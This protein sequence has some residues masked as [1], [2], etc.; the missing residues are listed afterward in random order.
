MET[1]SGTAV[2]DT[3]AVVYPWC[4]FLRGRLEIEERE[5]DGSLLKSPWWLLVAMP[6]TRR[7]A[8]AN[9][10]PR[11]REALELLSL[12]ALCDNAAWKWLLRDKCGVYFDTHERIRHEDLLMPRFIFVLD[13]HTKET[14]MWPTTLSSKFFFKLPATHVCNDDYVRA[15]Q[16]VLSIMRRIAPHIAAG[17]ASTIHEYPATHNAAKRESAMEI[18]FCLYFAPRVMDPVAFSTYLHSVLRIVQG[19]ASSDQY[20]GDYADFAAPFTLDAIQLNLT[21]FEI[22]EPVARVLTELFRLGVKISC[23]QLPLKATDFISDEECP[24]QALGTCLNAAVGVRETYF[25][26]LESDDD[27]SLLP[28]QSS[29]HWKN[30]VEA[31][32][33][34][35][36]SVDDRRFAALCA[37]LVES[38]CVKELTLESVFLNDSARARNL[39]WKWL[40]YALFSRET[41]TSVRKLVI[42]AASLRADDVDAIASVVGARFPAKQLLDPLWSIDDQLQDAHKDDAIHSV[43]LRRETVICLEPACCEAEWLSASVVLHEDAVFAVIN[44]NPASEWIEILVPGYGKCWVHRHFTV[45]SFY[46]REEETLSLRPRNPCAGKITS[47]TLALDRIEDSQGQVVASLIHLIGANLTSLVIQTNRLHGDC[48]DSILQSCPKL[49]TLSLKGAQIDTMDVFATA[50]EKYQCQLASITLNDFRIDVESLTRFAY[51]LADRKHPAAI[52]LRELCFGSFDRHHPLDESSMLAFVAMLERNKTLEYL[53]L[54]V[55]SSLFDVYAP[56]MLHHHHKLLTSPTGKLRFPMAQR[57]AFLSVISEHEAA[58]ISSHDDDH[59]HDNNNDEDTESSSCSSSSSSSSS[60]Q[61]SS[62]KSSSPPSSPQYAD[63]QPEA[64]KIPHHDH[65]HRMQTRLDSNTITLIFAFAETRTLRR[66]CLV[67]Y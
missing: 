4:K 33:I 10:L 58:T 14:I 12:V 16:E 26:E 61:P 43:L 29:L 60:S 15:R 20:S 11:M 48:L 47:F 1:L 36:L 3:W 31:L 6:K 56:S 62:P 19:L 50:Y 32:V 54:H 65:R 35:D 34:N 9:H 57:L 55:G 30:N 66:V 67:E 51:T 52:H 24:R 18:P 13:D 53:E 8:G 64:T 44:N 23:L 59:H 7:S 63:K 40:A 27:G 2:Q 22:T 25:N 17:Y 42:S 38:T 37:A 5:S 28:C 49:K 45:K 46:E 41:R 21:E 39:K